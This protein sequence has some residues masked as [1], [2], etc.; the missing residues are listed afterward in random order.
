DAGS[1]L[2]SVTLN[3]LGSQTVTATDTVTASITG[4]A[5]V[6]VVHLSGNFRDVR[7]QRKFNGLALA[8]F[9]DDDGTVGAGN[10]T[11]T[12]D[13]GDGSTSPGTI[14]SSAR[15]FTVTGSH[16]FASPPGNQ[17]II[18]INDTKNGFSTQVTGFIHMWPLTQSR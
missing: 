7:A 14:Q 8:D 11:A 3:T 16:A 15:G 12:I 18:T 6:N 1:H 9:T 2:F 5:S 10:F 17:G 4:S 13:W